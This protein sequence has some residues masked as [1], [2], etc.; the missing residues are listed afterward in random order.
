MLSLADAGCSCFLRLYWA[1]YKVALCPATLR[2]PLS[3]QA[4]ATTP[5]DPF[6]STQQVFV[7]VQG[8]ACR[9]LVAKTR[10]VLALRVHHALHVPALLRARSRGQPSPPAPSAATLPGLGATKLCRGVSGRVCV[11]ATCMPAAHAEV[12]SPTEMRECMYDHCK[13]L[14]L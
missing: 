4:K 2:A 6:A 8:G 11:E 7:S 5:Q 9:D 1:M 13:W 3:Q 10:V 14:S 12:R